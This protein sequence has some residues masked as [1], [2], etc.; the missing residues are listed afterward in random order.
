M[1]LCEHC[2]VGGAGEGPGYGE[3]YECLFLPVVDQIRLFFATAA[4][5]RSRSSNVRSCPANVRSSVPNVRSCRP[6]VA[7]L[8]RM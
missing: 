6:F 4:N 7:L 5:V 3:I 8:P 2:Y 1:K